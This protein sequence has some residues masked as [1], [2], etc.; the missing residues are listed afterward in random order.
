MHGLHVNE[1][2]DLLQTKLLSLKNV[3]GYVDIVTGT[4]HH[5]FEE[6]KL[7]PAIMDYISKRYKFEER[8]GKYG[9][10]FRIWINR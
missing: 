5:S 8:G 6:S 10:T 1:A 2:L 4:G 9:G 3:D 7:R